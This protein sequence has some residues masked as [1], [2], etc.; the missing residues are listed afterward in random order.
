M[1]AAARG[2]HRRLRG[3][4]RG[5]RGTVS[6]TAT[7]GMASCWLAEKVALLRER[8]PDILV[9]LC[10]RNDPTNLA[11]KT[12]DIAL[13]FGEPQ[14][15]SLFGCRVAEVHFGLYAARRYLERFGVPESP[16]DLARH[17]LIRAHGQI[18][19]FRQVQDLHALMAEAEASAE[20]DSVWAQLALADQG[21]GVICTSSYIARHH[22]GLVRL[23]PGTFDVR[24]PL[25]MLT[26]VDVRDNPRIR[27]VMEFLK[28][29]FRRD[30]ERVFAGFEAPM[31][32]VA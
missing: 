21:L 3:L 20:I 15:P 17:R 28:T 18:A 4:E 26:H 9:Q 7:E 27:L 19:R 5:L 25:W 11:Q 30:R 1:E 24:V 32:A 16:A 8:A 2:L 22:P 13:R 29:E 10:V 31:V 12:V 23:M 6:V 14:S